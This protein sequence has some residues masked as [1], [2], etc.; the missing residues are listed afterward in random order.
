MRA[1]LVALVLAGCVT[2]DDVGEDGQLAPLPPPGKEDG[3]YH[4][5]LRTDVDSSRTDV[6]KVT[7]QWEDK[8]PEAGIAWAANSGLTWDEKYTAWI[9]SLS[10]TPGV[11]GWS[12]T[13]TLTTPWGKTLPA[14]QLEC[15]ETALFLRITF[16]AWYGLPIQFEAM[17][18]STRIYFGHFGIRTQ[19]G[20]Y[21]G[22][23]EFAIRYKDYSG[24]DYAKSWPHDAALR[25]RIIHGGEDT[26][27][28]LSSDAVFGTYLDELHLNKRVGYFTV[29]ALDYLGSANLA[30]SA[31][32]FNL[33]PD[34]VKPGD[35]L[36]ERWQANGIGH[37]LVVKDVVPV[38]EAAL[39]VT[40][41]SGSM[42]RRQGVKAS[43]T[44]AKEYFTGDYTGGPG[45]GQLGGGL[46]RFRVAKKRNGYW[47]NTWMDGDE[48]HWINSTDIARI[49][50]RPARFE[51]LLGEVPLDQQK[52]ELIAQIADARHH[53]TLYPSSC[54]AREQRENAF[55][56][57][58]DVESRLS[59]KST[60][61]V[62]AEQ[63]TLEDYV[64]APLEYQESMTCCWDSS[65][66]AMHDIIMQQ[67]AAQKAADDAMSVCSAPVVFQAEDGGYR[68]WSDYAA[69]IGRSAEWR[70]YSDDEACGRHA[71]TLAYSSATP[72]CSL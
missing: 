57:L 27:P 16:A 43:G 14:P 5:G 2:T 60:D 70:A 61:Q 32:T 40:L 53:L 54:A 72:Y 45:Y 68:R 62:D 37:T 63:R 46:K 39:D 33:Q 9:N 55:R 20:N 67:A 12:T 8:S 18:G 49:E 52:A 50:A 38:G 30:D 21:K 44:A 56:A 65:T 35:L 29:L 59:Q 22:M 71:D 69:S 34:A 15:A 64:F 3:Q 66:S 13:Y 31:N 19:T 26:Q 17:D 36:L 23:P 47:T 24:T 10:W 11:D 42:P 7:H 1:L 41:V 58:Y 4:A 51:S 6:W 28:E 25:T 48:A